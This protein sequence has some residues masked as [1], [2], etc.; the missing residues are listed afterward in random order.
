MSESRQE[1]VCQTA[2]GG[3]R[4]AGSRV[5]LDSVVHAYWSG[6]SPEAI[7]LEFPSLTLEQVFGAIAFYLREQPQ[8]DAYLA[9]QDA[10]CAQLRAASETV[11]ATLLQRLRS[12]R[13]A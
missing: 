9:R 7:A 10:T 13:H 11:N 4:I 6:Q 8:I 3:W 2:E 1:Y 12:A 5:S